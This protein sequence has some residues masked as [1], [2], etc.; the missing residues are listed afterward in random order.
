MMRAMITN[1]IPVFGVIKLGEME[2]W[3]GDLKKLNLNF[4]YRKSNGRILKSSIK[5]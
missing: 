1:L 3:W 2:A 5:K 4:H